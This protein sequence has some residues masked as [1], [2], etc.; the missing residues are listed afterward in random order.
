ML[1]G[2]VALA[3][4]YLLRA[5]YSRLYGSLLSGPAL[6]AVVVSLVAGLPTTVLVY[7]RRFAAAPDEPSPSAS[8]RTGVMQAEIVP[9]GLTAGRRDRSFVW[10]SAVSSP[11]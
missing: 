9:A 1:A 5:D 8:G 3:R 7:L 10:R 6:A 4:I 11:S 2:A